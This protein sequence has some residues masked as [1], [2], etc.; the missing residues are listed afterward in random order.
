LVKALEA[1][2]FIFKGGKGSHRVYS[3]PDVVEIVNYQPLKG[4]ASTTPPLP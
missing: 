2:D 3:R 4:L 1:F